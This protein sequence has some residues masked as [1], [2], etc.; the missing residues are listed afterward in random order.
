MGEDMFMMR[1]IRRHKLAHGVNLVTIVAYNKMHE[2]MFLKTTI[3][4]HFYLIGFKT[5]KV[6]VYILGFWAYF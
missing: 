5:F 2:G 3:S 6:K 4:F 1:C